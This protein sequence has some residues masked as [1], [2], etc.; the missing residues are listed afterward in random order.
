MTPSEMGDVGKQALDSAKAAKRAIKAYK[1]F[2]GEFNNRNLIT[3][4]TSKKKGSFDQELLNAS[5][6]NKKIFSNTSDGAIEQIIPLVNGLIKQG[7]AGKKALGAM[8][9]HVMLDLMNAATKG[10]SRKLTDG[11]REWS[12]ANFI[13]RLEQLGDDK[14]QVVF[15]N[16]PSAL[17]QIYKLRDAGDLKTQFSQV[18]RAS[19]TGDDIFNRL[20]STPVVGRL[21]ST[22]GGVKGWMAAQA[23][24]GAQGAAKKRGMKKKLRKALDTSPV[25]RQNLS[26]FK[27]QFPELAA[28]L[29]IGDLMTA[30]TENND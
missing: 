2:A 25:L 19:G 3:K 11:V 6:V 13:K 5:E 18:A 20:G 22:V 27:N 29:A 4:L 1:D 10:A 14:L 21:F 12:G 28:S 7:D 16:N 8:Q 24:E 26:Q 9:S 17:K 23:I 30:E 15:K